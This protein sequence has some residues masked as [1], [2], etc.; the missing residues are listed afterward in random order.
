[1]LIGLIEVCMHAGAQVIASHGCDRG[2]D[3]IA[4]CARTG[5]GRLWLWL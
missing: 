1:M 2:C 3:C 4:A 5:A